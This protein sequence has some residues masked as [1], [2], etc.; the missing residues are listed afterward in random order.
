MIIQIKLLQRI[1]DQT[2]LL[3]SPKEIANSILSFIDEKE[4]HYEYMVRLFNSDP[5]FYIPHHETIDGQIHLSSTTF[6]VNYYRGY[7]KDRRDPIE[8]ALQNLN[9]FMGVTANWSISDET[10]V[11]I[12][13]VSYKEGTPR[14]KYDGSEVYYIK[15]ED[16]PR[17]PVSFK[18]PQRITIKFNRKISLEKMLKTTNAFHKKLVALLPHNHQT[19]GTVGTK[20]IKDDEALFLDY[21]ASDADT[22]DGITVTA[23]QGISDEIIECLHQGIEFMIGKDEDELIGQITENEYFSAE[24]AL[25]HK[26]STPFFATGSIKPLADVDSSKSIQRNIIHSIVYNLLGDYGKFDIRKEN[27]WSIAELPELGKVHI[28]CSS[29]AS[30]IIPTRGKRRVFDKTPY[31]VEIVFEKPVFLHSIGAHRRFGL[32]KLEPI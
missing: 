32:G 13:Y 31:E 19:R 1:L 11:P 21:I 30:N 26:T 27:E 12:N 28:K 14:Q 2:D 16:F 15:E 18:A 23:Y 3:P 22:F 25:H 7:Q 10:T 24:P 5:G 29:I 20:F 8:K 4:E 6:H 9:S 17:A